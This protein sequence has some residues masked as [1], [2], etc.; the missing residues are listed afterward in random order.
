MGDASILFYLQNYV[1]LGGLLYKYSLE[2]I[3]KS[4][5]LTQ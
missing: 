5:F 4:G 3:P 1:P 2:P